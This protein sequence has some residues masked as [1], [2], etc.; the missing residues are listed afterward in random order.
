MLVIQMYMLEKIFIWTLITEY[1]M[2]VEKLLKYIMVF[3]IIE[4]AEKQ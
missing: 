3:N 2:S 1:F 4:Y